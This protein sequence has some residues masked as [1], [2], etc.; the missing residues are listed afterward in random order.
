MIWEISALIGALAILILVAFTVPAI[1][2][3]KR[4]LKKV[5]EVT[6]DLNGHLPN[7]MANLDNITT[8]LSK[9]MTAG[10]EQVKV[11]ETAVEDVKGLVDDV[12]GMERKI[13]RQLDSPLIR[14]IGTVA[15]AVKA[16][17]V[18]MNVI[19]SRKKR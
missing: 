7:I 13:K 6:A 12:V 8:D 14:T 4:S 3:L 1:I 11:L 5:E 10:R 9:I 18:F 15:A 19:G 2:Q 17:Q 16:A